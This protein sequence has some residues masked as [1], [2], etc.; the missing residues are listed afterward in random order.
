MQRQL[1]SEPMPPTFTV[2]LGLAWPCSSCSCYVGETCSP[3]GEARIA[4][5]DRRRVMTP[6]RYRF[7]YTFEVPASPRGAMTGSLW[8]GADA[9]AALVGPAAVLTWSEYTPE[10]WKL[11]A[12]VTLTPSDAQAAAAERVSFILERGLFT[13]LRPGDVI[14]LHEAAGMGV[15]ILRHER[16]IAAAG[17]ASALTD[18]PLG[19]DVAVRFPNPLLVVPLPVGPGETYRQAESASARR[20]VE[21]T[22]EGETLMSR[23]GRP[24]M[25]HYEA[26]IGPSARDGEPLISIERRHLCPETAAHTSAALLD[27]EPP[28]II[29]DRRNC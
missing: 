3:L 2:S 29:W 19:R 13:V 27:K 16:L 5:Y 28:V 6:R 4:Q 24:Q 9:G 20:P 22:I 21:L 11:F 10:P 14:H 8:G 1:P 17:A 15:S 7:S 26:M 18:M 12:R 23:R 25:G